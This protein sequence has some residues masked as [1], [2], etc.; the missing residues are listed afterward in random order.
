MN[1]FKHYG[2][3]VW[4]QAL[5]ETN[6]V[7]ELKKSGLEYTALPDLE[8][9]VY[10][11]INDGNERYA[12]VYYPDIPEE[13]L[14]EVYIIEKIPDDLSWDNVIEDYRQ[15][16]RGHDPMKLPTRARLLYDEADRIAYEWEKEDPDFAKNFWHRPTGY[17]DPKRFKSALTLLGTSIEELKKMDHSDT[18]EIDEL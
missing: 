10:K 14:Q 9:E 6:W 12:L 11:Y 3:D 17:I 18:P 8:H 5:F 7:E 2:K 16:S 13:D 15:Q 4:R 1:K